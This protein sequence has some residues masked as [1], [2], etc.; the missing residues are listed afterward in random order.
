MFPG[1]HDT[2]YK[3]NNLMC[4]LKGLSKQRGLFSQ[5]YSLFI[6]I[7]SPASNTLVGL[8]DSVNGDRSPLSIGALKD[9]S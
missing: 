8:D 4:L 2:M 9:E 1:W 7:A 6:C 5:V 3:Q